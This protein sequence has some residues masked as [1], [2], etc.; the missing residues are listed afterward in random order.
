M[1]AFTGNFPVLNVSFIR[2]AVFHSDSLEILPL[3]GVSGGRE[4]NSGK[5]IFAFP[6]IWVVHLGERICTQGVVLFFLQVI[7]VQKNKVEVMEGCLHFIHRV[8]HAEI[9][10]L[11]MSLKRISLV[12]FENWVWNPIPV[13]SNKENFV[14]KN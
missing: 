12:L 14:L 9:W 2:A 8:Y 10:F 6:V 4:G 1:F 13:V 11:S 7:G 5:N 3:L